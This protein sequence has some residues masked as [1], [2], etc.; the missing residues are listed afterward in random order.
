MHGS[1]RYLLFTSSAA[2]STVLALF[3]SY[4][5]LQLATPFRW[6]LFWLP[7]ANPVFVQLAVYIHH[8]FSSVE[9]EIAKLRGLKYEHKKV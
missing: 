1:K 9:R 2:L 3:W 7:L 4:T 5:L 6:R 8:S